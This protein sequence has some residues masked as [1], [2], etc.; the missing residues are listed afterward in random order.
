VVEQTDIKRQGLNSPDTACGVLLSRIEGQMRLLLMKR[1]KG[2]FWCHLAG[3]LEAHETFWQAILREMDEELSLIASSLYYADHI[4]TYY[5]VEADRINLVP[6][7]V[8]FLPDD[9]K[10]LLNSEHAQYAWCDLQEAR[11]LVP[12]SNQKL[13]YEHVWRNF[14]ENAPSEF[15]NIHF[16]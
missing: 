15:L 1:T 5:D 10:P 4:V 12:F 13:L 6:A 14:I 3:H 11:T 2:G 7:F 16:R 8:I 9:A